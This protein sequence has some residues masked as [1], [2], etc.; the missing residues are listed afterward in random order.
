M[1]VPFAVTEKK[2]QVK[3]F[4]Q[5]K[6]DQNL[7]KTDPPD[8]LGHADLLSS[9]LKEILL[10]LLN[11]IRNS[12]IDSEVLN[13]E[14][15]KADL[16]QSW[17][18]LKESSNIYQLSE[19]QE[20][21]KK[22]ILRQREVEQIHHQNQY[23]E[24]SQIVGTL[25]EGIGEFTGSNDDFDKR[26]NTALSH[27]GHVAVQLDDL[28][29]IRQ[30]IAQRVIHAKKALHEKK[31][32]NSKRQKVLARKVEELEERLSEAQEEML[33]DEM[34]Q[35][36]NRRAFD[37]R[38]EESVKRREMFDIDMGLLLF[39]IDH[40]KKVNDTHGHQVGDRLLTALAQQA[41][42]VF[43]ADDFVA[44]YGGE[45]FAVLIYCSSSEIAESAAERLR[46][47]IDRKGF[48]YVKDGTPQ[49]LGIT[50]SV[51]VAWC[52]EDDT[53]ESLIRRADECL[54]LAKESGRNKVCVESELDNPNRD[55]MLPLQGKE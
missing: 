43:R 38:I 45:E 9:K 31:A 37:R 24:Y 39:D 48:R 10:M 21:L 7:L 1:Y 17:I 40:F 44:R 6:T 34:T 28:K 49:T 51:G 14:A 32:R 30:Q 18:R 16:D 33:I 29:Q 2:E 19:I 54:Y 35:V 25:I 8:D 53:P 11:I 47:S 52:R 23:T 5:R 36:Y 27:I 55:D 20:F 46:S 42:S 3:M 22:L 26:L 41:K 4:G 15:F 13:S 50:V 12:T